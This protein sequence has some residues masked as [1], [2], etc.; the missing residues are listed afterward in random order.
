ML[1]TNAPLHWYVILASCEL[2]G[3]KGHP[4]SCDWPICR[5]SSLLSTKAPT[6][7]PSAHTYC[8]PTK[9]PT[10]ALTDLYPPLLHPDHAPTAY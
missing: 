10:K 1:Y 6:K 8:T 4:L 2:H 5:D 7:A 9:A 3:R